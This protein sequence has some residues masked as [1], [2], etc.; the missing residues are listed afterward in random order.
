MIDVGHFKNLMM[1]LY[2]G[3]KVIIWDVINRIRISS[4]NLTSVYFLFYFHFHGNIVAYKVAEPLLQKYGSV[5]CRL[6]HL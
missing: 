6:R 1:Q 4:Y 2:L 3:N 5:P